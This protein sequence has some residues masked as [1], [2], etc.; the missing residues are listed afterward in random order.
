MEKKEKRTCCK[1]LWIRRSLKT[2]LALVL[3][4]QMLF[5]NAV[6]V[7]AADPASTGESAEAESK[8]VLDSAWEV[9]N[10]TEGNLTVN[11]DGS[12][13]IRTEG[14]TIDSSMNN[15]LYYQLPNSTDYDFTV[16]VSG[17]FTANYQGAH[18]MIASGKNLE[19]AVG[20]VRRYHGYLGGNYGTNLLMGVM[21]DGN[22][23][24]YYEAAGDIGNEFYLKLQKQNGRITGFYAEE[25]SDNDSDWNQIIDPTKGDVGYVD[26]GSALIDPENIYL[27]IAAAN[28]GGNTPTEI[29]FSDL[30]VGGIPVAF[31]ADPSALN[32]V[33]LSGEKEMEVDAEQQLILTGMDYEGNEI[34]EFDSVTYTSSDEDVA[35]VDENGVVTGLANGNAVITAEAVLGGVTKTASLSI[36]V[37][38]IVAEE[39]WK[40]A[41]PDGSTEMTVELLTGG[42]LQYRAEQNGVENIGSSPLGLV[43]SVGD[44]SKGLVFKEASAVKEI[45]DSYTMI[46]GKSD[47]YTDHCNEQTLTFTLKNDDS[48]EFDLIM[49]VYDDGTA[50][51]YA[52]RTEEKGTEIRISDETSGLQ[53]PEGAD[54]YWM[55]YSS[56]TWNYEG[57]YQT[58]TTEGL[59][60]NATPSIPFLYGKD[61][62]WTLFSEADLNGTYCGSMFTVG[63]GGLLDVSFCKT[64]GTTPV[65]TTTP[66]KSPWRAAITGGP[67]DIVENT[68][69]E[70]L[71]TPADYETYDYESWVEPGLSSWS[72]VA[73]WGSGISDQSKAE[74]HLNWIEFGG[75]IG[76][77]YY[78]L[79]EG[80]NKGGRGNYSGMRDWWP[81]V[82]ACAEENGVKLWVWVHVS[83]IDTQEER[84]RLFK[85]WSE[86]GIVGVKPDFFDGEDQA[87]MQLY[88]DLYKDAAKYH[89]MLLVHG[90]NKPTGEIRTYPNVYGR[91]AIRGQESGGITAEQ[92]T[93]IPFIRAAIG[94]AEVTEEI[95]SKDY[96]KTTMG[97]QI[98][99]TALIEDGIHSMGSAPDVYRSI[100]EAMSYYTDY[101][102]GWDDTEFVNGEV[103][104]YLSIARKAGNSWYVSGI[105]VDPRQMEAALDFLDE[106]TEYTALLYKEN[107]RQDID[108]EIITGVTSETVLNIDVLY[109]GGYALH[110]LPKDEV[111]GVKSIT[112]QPSEV[113]VE[114][115]H[116]S[117]P[118]ELTVA[119]EDAKFQ[120]VVWSS[121]DENIATVDQNGVIRGVTAGMTTV[122]VRSAFDENVK[123]EIK[124]T[125]DP[126]RYVLDEEM[127]TILNKN[128][129]VLINNTDSA[130]ITT[131]HG[132]LGENNWNNMFAMDVPD[133]SS[134][135]TITAKISGGLNADYQGGFITVFDKEN[136]DDLSVAAGRRYHSYLMG[137][138]PQSLGVMTNGG[139]IGE[140]YC[141]DENY[142]SDVYLKIAKEGNTFICSYSYDGETWT[143]ITNKGTEVTVTNDR[144]AASEN[145][146]VGFYAGSGGGS[147]PIDVTISEFTFNGEKIPVAVDTQ[148]EQEEI[149]TAVLEYALNLA[150]EADTDGVAASVVKLFNEARAEAQDILTRVQSGDR[151]VTQEMVDQSW[152]NL[153]KAMQYLSFKQGDKTDLQKVIDLA[154]TIDLTEYLEEGQ[155]AFADA[156]A[157]AEAVL[158][159]GDA[160][161]DEVDQAWRDLL[162]AMSE[163]RLKPNK[164]ALEALINEANGLSTENADEETAA[165]FRSALAMAVTVY[166]NEQATEDE[167][168]AAYEQLHAAAGRL[169]AAADGSSGADDTGNTGSTGENADKGSAG[170]AGEGEKSQDTQSGEKTAADSG[171]TSDGSAAGKSN[172]SVKTGDQTEIWILIGVM[173]I[174]LTG[175]V[176]VIRKRRG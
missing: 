22:P 49:R 164:D 10:P 108:M 150:E 121:A 95:R 151:T 122:T 66:F 140:F 50:Y 107:G 15:V 46:S 174:A 142:D 41:S 156:L 19:N 83:D 72:W 173:M 18:L 162:K 86:E 33:T 82:K 146:C 6:S 88:D 118:V 110:I 12:I 93:L 79:D 68:M 87:H 37:G 132:V 169:M 51:R 80:W 167:V 7:L 24:E 99:L 104:E 70:N 89:L 77:K 111:D 35:V 119:P 76:W 127:W 136:P 130:T 47:V 44:F 78:I 152:M 3:S 139:S 20:V 43:T 113:T 85:E 172:V 73:N 133:G 38:D 106:D 175:G 21:Q 116:Y 143:E 123:A 97:F 31:T 26:K 98:A 154:Y 148:A 102:D 114:E 40:L 75:E 48:V 161:Q 120:D 11:E 54:V 74:T 69:I 168:T 55:D 137:S 129:N 134:D 159:D 126:A 9:E 52:V 131:E 56:S 65:V 8:V 63:E 109:G 81:E 105:S 5:G 14:G 92:Y 61:G 36:Q 125:V 23:S 171:Q 30:R 160:M 45:N 144:L 13:T 71:S 166:E 53:L 176:L 124:V 115:G 1:N 94:P 100:P 155:Q 2:A 84:D 91:E 163:L 39:T 29:T 25:Y 149:S 42:T 17:E 96:S 57:Q 153:I 138:H 141:A 117:D 64:Q 34:T 32:S 135:F 16:K 147:T 157:A 165:A 4:G 59:E 58:T 103:G 158:A 145:L 62:V 28:G 128:D 101:P 90:A 112:A 170:A 67:E 60:V 27:A